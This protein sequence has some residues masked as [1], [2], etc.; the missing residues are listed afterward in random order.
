MTIALYSYLKYFLYTENI[1]HAPLMRRKPPLSGGS[2][3]I[4]GCVVLHSIHYKVVGHNLRYS[5][6]F[7][8]VM[9]NFSYSK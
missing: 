1:R 6:E 8:S 7:R 2:L 3:V 4:V 9:Y 5:K